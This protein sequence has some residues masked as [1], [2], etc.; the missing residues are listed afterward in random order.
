ML[1]KKKKRLEILHILKSEVPTCL[2]FIYD[3]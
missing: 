2:V 3:Y 1:M